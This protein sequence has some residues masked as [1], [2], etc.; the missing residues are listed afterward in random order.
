MT[1]DSMFTPALTTMPNITM[2][3]PPS[4]E[5]GIA[6]TTAPTFGIKPHSTKKS[7]PRVTTDRLITPVIEIKPTFWLNDVLGSPAKMPAI[8]LPRPSA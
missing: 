4:T 6:A 7:A 2:T 3:P 1:V 8:K 5:M